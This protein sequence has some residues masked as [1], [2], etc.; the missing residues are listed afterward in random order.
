MQL[1][2]GTPGGCEATP[3]GCE[4]AVHAALRFLGSGF[5]DSPKNFSE[6]WL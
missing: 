6:T 3:G 5:A 4:A 1:G 2:F